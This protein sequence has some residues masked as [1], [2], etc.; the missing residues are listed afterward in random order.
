MWLRDHRRSS[1]VLGAVLSSS[2]VFYLITRFG[3]WLTYDLYP[4]A[5]EGLMAAYTAGIPFLR[6]SVLGDLLFATVFFG[7]F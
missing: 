1:L 6:N 3:S 5:F 2:V 7:G 4:R